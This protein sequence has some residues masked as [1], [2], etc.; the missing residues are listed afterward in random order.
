MGRARFAADLPPLVLLAAVPGQELTGASQSVRTADRGQTSWSRGNQMRR[1]GPLLKSEGL[2]G[3]RCRPKSARLFAQYSM[4]S[5][6]LVSTE[7]AFASFMF[8]TLYDR[9]GRSCVRS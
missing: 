8:V 2:S 1:D 9:F 4:A 7:Y 6:V 3:R 5:P